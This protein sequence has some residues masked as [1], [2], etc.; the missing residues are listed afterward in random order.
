MSPSASTSPGRLL[1]RLLS[2][3]FWGGWV[4]WL[5]LAPQGPKMP[6]GLSWDKFQHAASYGLLTFLAGRLLELWWPLRKAWVGAV[7]VVIAYGGGLEIL[8]G[9]LTE[10]RQPSFADLLAD[11]IGAVLVA[12]VFLRNDLKQLWKS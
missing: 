12:V 8:Q 2:L 6:P 3:L 4:L 1:L 7:V 10:T 11:G 9:V 5:S